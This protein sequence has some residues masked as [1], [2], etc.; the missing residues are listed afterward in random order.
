MLQMPRQGDPRLTRASA[1]MQSRDWQ[2]SCIE[3]TTT[4][5]T[6]QVPEN[7]RRAERHHHGAPASLAGAERPSPAAGGRCTAE[8]A[9]P[10]GAAAGSSRAPISGPPNS[11]RT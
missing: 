3:A 2:H 5:W 7:R 9:A 8:A 1:S 4:F 6:I 10:A 11:S